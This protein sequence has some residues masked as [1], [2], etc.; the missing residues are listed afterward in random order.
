[1]KRQQTT[2]EHTDTLII[3]AGLSGIGIAYYLQKE[4]PARSFTLLEARTATGGTWDLFR[5]PGIRSDSD[6]HTFGYEFKPWVDNHAIAGADKILDYLRNTA[7]ENDINR[8]IRFQHKVV[9]ATWSTKQACWCVEVERED[10]EERFSMTCN[11]LFS[12]AGYYRYD[13]GYTPDFEGVERFGGAVVHPQ[14]WP[15]DLDYQD[16]QVLVIGSGATA[17]T[18]VP[19]MT[20]KAG[21]VTMLQRTPSYIISLPSEDVIANTLRKW[22]P[23][24]IAYSITRRKN[25][26]LSRGIWRFCQRFPTLARKAIRYSNKRSLPENYPVDEHF[27][28]PYNPWDQRLC[29]APDGDFFQAISEGRASVVTD[30]IQTFTEKG[31]R[32]TSGQEL[33]AD[34]IVTATGLNLQAFGGIDMV[35]DGKLV[36]M[37]EKVAYKGMMLDGVPNFAFAI[38]YTNSSW[39][40]KV[41]LLCE[42]FCRI[43]AY[44]DQHDK[45]ICCPTL[46]QPDMPTR[47]LLDFGAGYVQRSLSKLPRQGLGAPWVIP[48]DYWVDKK[49]MKD[50]PVEDPNLRFYSATAERRVHDTPFVQTGLQTEGA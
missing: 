25:I 45:S 29:V 41:G 14:Q 2:V 42:H 33:E 7:S 23:D 16:K 15:E 19:A 44:M 24:D 39:T 38:G 13:H 37:S 22:L 46:P 43:L 3:G 26:A 48:M 9:K 34:I 47:P 20:D 5:Y 12:A 32:L 49:L 17:V 30:H 35:V 10:T 11:W 40:L 28:P 36:D 18:L 27:N 31:V 6:L 8:H 21:H 50:G 1:M 4:Q